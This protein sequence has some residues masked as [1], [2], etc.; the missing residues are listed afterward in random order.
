MVSVLPIASAVGGYYPPRNPS[1]SARIFTQCVLWRIPSGLNSPSPLPAWHP[2]T[3]QT[4]RGESFRPNDHDEF[5]LLFEHLFSLQHRHGD[6]PRQNL[7]APSVFPSQLQQASA[8]TPRHQEGALESSRPHP[9]LAC[10]P[11][12]AA[13][14]TI[15]SCKTLSL[16]LLGGQSHRKCQLCLLVPI[17]SVA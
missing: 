1:L 10:R 14:G 12:E 7:S 6:A 8:F 9:C 3:R 5:L 4:Y 15:Q 2:T 16:N 17:I 11:G 13:W